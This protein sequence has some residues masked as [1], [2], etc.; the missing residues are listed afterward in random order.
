MG[1]KTVASWRQ[2]SGVIALQ[3]HVS[4]LQHKTVCNSFTRDRLNNN[5]VKNRRGRVFITHYT[6]SGG[7]DFE[8]GLWDRFM[9]AKIL[10]SFLHTHREP[11]RGASGTRK[12]SVTQRKYRNMNWV[13]GWRKEGVNMFR[14][15]RNSAHWQLHYRINFY[16]FLLRSK[17]LYYTHT[18]FTL[19]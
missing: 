6:Y 9:L 12:N 1:N 11:P 10:A 16:Q 8:S 17:H 14:T 3:V 7:T 15:F 5:I 13:T 2:Y 19:S 18:L 4:K